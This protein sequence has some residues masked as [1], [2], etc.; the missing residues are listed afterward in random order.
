MG[1]R[2]TINAYWQR[3]NCKREQRKEYDKNGSILSK[4]F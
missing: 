3:T 4:K 1:L 2:L